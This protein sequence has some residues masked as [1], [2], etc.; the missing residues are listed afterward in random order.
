[1]LRFGSHSRQAFLEYNT[2]SQEHAEWLQAQLGFIGQHGTVYT[3]DRDAG[4][5][6][7]VRTLTHPDLYGFE[8]IQSP[9][10][11]TTQL[12]TATDLDGDYEWDRTGSDIQLTAQVARS[13]Y[14]LAG[15][16]YQRVSPPIPQLRSRRTTASES[17]WRDLLAPFSPRVYD[18]R[19]RLQDAV[20]WFEF[21]GWEPPALSEPPWL[22]EAELTDGTRCPDCGKYYKQ[23][24]LH[25][26][27]SACAGP[28]EPTG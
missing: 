5:T 9:G 10:A 3:R 8:S 11:S 21:I 15:S 19:V 23:V 27:Q 7:R 1:M 4:V 2:S 16:L 20:A 22:Q 6:Y 24:K 18:D 13:W 28:D 25:W 14:T 26:A 12:P 17:A